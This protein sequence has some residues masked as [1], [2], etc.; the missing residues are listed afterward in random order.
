MGA[1]DLLALVAVVVSLATAAAGIAQA[2]RISY[3]EKA[4]IIV[5]YWDGARDGWV[6]RNVGEGP[7]L[8]VVVAQRRTDT[9]GVWYNPVVVPPIPPGGDF[10]IEWLPADIFDPYGLGVRYSDARD[11]GHSSQ[12]FAYTGNEGSKVKTRH[13]RCQNIRSRRFGGIG[14]RIFR[15][16]LQLTKE[17]ILMGPGRLADSS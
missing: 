16:N 10:T 11:K 7:A 6:I 2:A 9:A 15:T 12:H 4:P 17:L 13:G 14:S 3:R 8:N 1:S 5:T